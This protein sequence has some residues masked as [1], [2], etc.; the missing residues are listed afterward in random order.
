V[1]TLC[2]GVSGLS[3]ERDSAVRYYVYSYTLL[4]GRLT[5]R[6]LGVFSTRSEALA[7]LRE[8]PDGLFIQYSAGAVR[9]MIME[10]E[11]ED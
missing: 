11:N 1:T 3:P 9:A 8:C 2:P 6:P 4:D 10:T 7:L 5:A